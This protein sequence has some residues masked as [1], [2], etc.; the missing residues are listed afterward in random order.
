MFQLVVATIMLPASLS[1]WPLQSMRAASALPDFCFDLRRFDRL[2]YFA[3][4]RF[5]WLLFFVPLGYLCPTCNGRHFFAAPEFPASFRK[6]RGSR[7][8]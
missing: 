2:S 5:R 1:G 6:I 7:A 4:T 8:D 3:Q